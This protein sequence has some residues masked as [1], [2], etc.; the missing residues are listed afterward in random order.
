[1]V[2]K[3]LVAGVMAF[4]RGN[5]DRRALFDFGPVERMT[6]TTSRGTPVIASTSNAAHS[7]SVRENR[8]SYGSTLA[9]IHIMQVNSP[10]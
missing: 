8:E 5:L 10:C 9:Y 1:M 6:T 7:R 4:A 3:L 2:L